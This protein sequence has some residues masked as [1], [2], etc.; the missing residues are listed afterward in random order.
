MKRKKS[1]RKQSRKRG[2]GLSFPCK[3][4]HKIGTLKVGE[5][6]GWCDQS[7][8]VINKVYQKKM[9]NKDGLRIAGKKNTSRIGQVFLDKK[10][11]CPH[12]IVDVQLSELKKLV[13]EAEKRRDYFRKAESRVKRK[14][15]TIQ[16]FSHL[17]TELSFDIRTR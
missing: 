2:N 17:T 5:G 14:N 8:V 11:G 9:Q 13:K 15:G 1:K 3:K 4:I 7:I 12:V 6:V 10:T 16:F